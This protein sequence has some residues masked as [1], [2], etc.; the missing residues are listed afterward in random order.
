VGGQEVIAAV[1]AAT[2]DTGAAMPAAATAGAGAAEPA[3]AAAGAATVMPADSAN[4]GIGEATAIYQSG[5]AFGTWN[6]QDFIKGFFYHLLC[7]RLPLA[8]SPAL[9]TSECERWTEPTRR[10]EP[11]AESCCEGSRRS[12]SQRR[13]G[14]RHI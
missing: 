8:C 6:Y 14:S 5:N 13:R 11:R 9:V 3:A 2:I 12:R 10:F 1:T 4:W 7:R